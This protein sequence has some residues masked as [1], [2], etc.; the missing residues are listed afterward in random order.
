M[1]GSIAKLNLFVPFLQTEDQCHRAL[2]VLESYLDRKYF[3]PKDAPTSIA[4]ARDALLAISGICAMFRYAQKWPS[5][6]DSII[7]VWPLIYEWLQFYERQNSRFP[8]FQIGETRID[9]RMSIITGL[10]AFDRLREVIKTYSGILDIILP[11]WIAE[12]KSSKLPTAGHVA[13]ALS[14]WTSDLSGSQ[15]HER[16][17]IPTGESELSIARMALN[18]LRREISRSPPVG[19]Y[20]T[21]DMRVLRSLSQHHPLSTILLQEG[22]L[23]LTCGLFRQLSSHY[24]SISEIERAEVALRCASY[25]SCI[26]APPNDAVL[27]LPKL[28]KAE[29]L[30]SLMRIS[31]LLSRSDSHY[32]EIW[33]CIISDILP[34]FSIYRNIFIYLKKTVELV[35]SIEPQDFGTFSV[36][37]LALKDLVKRREKNL[38]GGRCREVCGNGNVNHFLSPYSIRRLIK[39]FAVSLRFCI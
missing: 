10:A 28:L 30:V 20:I 8:D 24:D 18:H 6:E 13:F 17:V 38:H 31:D 22:S 26:M 35:E 29:M 1:N 16:V 11:L 27:I 2:R 5:V 3:P 25:F 12:N 36:A 32:S 39:P 14:V 4:D 33:L 37:W 7:Q 19:R 23:A 34:R 9:M 15:I 21:A